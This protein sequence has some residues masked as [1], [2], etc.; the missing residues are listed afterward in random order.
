MKNIKTT[1]IAKGIY[2][3]VNL[4][5]NKEY[6]ARLNEYHKQWDIFIFE[7]SL[8]SCTPDEVYSQTYVDF[9]SCKIHASR[10]Y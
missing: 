1:K 5:T 9:K 4:D 8:I 2:K 7:D 3:I 10:N 6:E